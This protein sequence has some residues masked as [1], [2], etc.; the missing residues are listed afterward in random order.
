M[1]NFFNNNMLKLSIVVGILLISSSLF[2][3][4]IIFLPQKEQVRIDQQKQEQLTQE[5]KDRETKEAFDSCLSNADVSLESSFISLCVGEEQI[6]GG[7]K[8]S[9]STGTIDDKIGFMTASN[10]YDRF[11]KRI[12]DKRD[13]DRTECFKRYPQK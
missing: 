8:A 11:F 13:K 10:L 9:C 7:N 5:Q 1:K 6:S 3:Y 12:L 4:Y 2:Y